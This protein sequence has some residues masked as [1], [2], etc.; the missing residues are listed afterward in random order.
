MRCII[1]AAGRG[2]RLGSLTNKKPKC[3]IQLNG[4][5]L[6]EHQLAILRASNIKDIG[7]VT[8][9]KRQLLSD[10]GLYE[11]HNNKWDKTNMVSSLECADSWLNKYHCIVSYGDIFY[12]HRAIKKLILSKDEMAITYDPNWKLL[13]EKRFDNPLDDAET[14]KLN[15][16][17]TISEIGKVPTDLNQIQGQYMGLLKFTPASWKEVKSIRSK[18]SNTMKSKMDMTTLLQK[19]ILK[20][21]IKVKGLIY[22]DNWGEI[23]TESDLNVYK[24]T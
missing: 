16:D 10:F 14:F 22:E 6:L 3:L 12:Q 19:I 23:D 17:S 7:I 1:L 4:K 15:A 24:N 18:M 13:W 5:S 20:N 11:F 9:Y 21:K 8:G 2:S